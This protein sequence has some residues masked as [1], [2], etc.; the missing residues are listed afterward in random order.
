MQA[1]GK[2]ATHIHRNCR[3]LNVYRNCAGTANYY[4]YTS[5]EF[6]IL[7]WTEI[8]P[9]IMTLASLK[10]RK[11]F[12]NRLEDAHISH[13]FAIC[14]WTYHNSHNTVAL[15]ISYPSVA[16]FLMRTSTSEVSLSL[17]AKMFQKKLQWDLLLNVPFL[18]HLVKSINRK[19]N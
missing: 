10:K 15:L 14:D 9:E 6:G 3:R 12:E 2:K 17:T 7:K 5:W 4:I 11:H 8:N 1:L 18:I 16:H 13:I 19:D